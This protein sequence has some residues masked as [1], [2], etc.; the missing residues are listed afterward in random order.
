MGTWPVS[1]T[2][3]FYSTLKQLITQEEF[4]AN[5][6]FI[7]LQDIWTEAKNTGHWS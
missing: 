3:V 7:A 5:N 1:K 6:L 4:N 2:L